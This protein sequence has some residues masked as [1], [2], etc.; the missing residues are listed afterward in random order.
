MLSNATLY[1]HMKDG[2][3]YWYD[4]TTQHLILDDSLQLKSANFK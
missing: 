3:Q 4:P 1:D 2:A